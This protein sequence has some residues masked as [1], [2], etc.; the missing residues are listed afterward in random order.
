MKKIISTFTLFYLTISTICV[1]ASAALDPK[2]KS[3]FADIGALQQANVKQPSCFI[4][5]AY[6]GERDDLL[7]SQAQINELLQL[8]GLRVIFHTN[9]DGSGLAVGGDINAFMESSVKESDFVVVYF[10]KQFAAR[11]KVFNSGVKNEV[12]HIVDRIAVNG[13]RFLIPILM[14]TPLESCVPT[15][16]RNLLIMAPFSQNNHFDINLFA[17]DLLKLF[18]LR[19]F[20]GHV[21]VKNSVAHYLQSV[22]VENLAQ[23]ESKAV[24]VVTPSSTKVLSKKT[25]LPTDLPSLFPLI[26]HMIATPDLSVAAACEDMSIFVNAWKNFDLTTKEELIIG[27][28][29]LVSFELPQWPERYDLPIKYNTLEEAQSVYFVFH[30]MQQ[31]YDRL[32][33]ELGSSKKL[34]GRSKKADEQKIDRQKREDLLKT[35][36]KPQGKQFVCKWEVL[37]LESIEDGLRQSKNLIF[38]FFLQPASDKAPTIMAI[39][40]KS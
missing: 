30:E 29:K 9:G 3:V 12:I 22:V 37:V 24:D 23:K 33:K 38:E 7:Q 31:L 18:P 4:V 16:L 6:A 25:V 15:A 21:G 19:F 2:L 13:S 17:I 27:F 10:T 28:S 39:M 36:L 40:Q 35:V 32:A 20:A 26:K 1:T 11:E 8:G 14:E 34:D 5:H